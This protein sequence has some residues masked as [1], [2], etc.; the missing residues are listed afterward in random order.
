VG[1]GTI[2]S[3]EVQSVADLTWDIPLQAM[4]GILSQCLWAEQDLSSMAMTL[5]HCVPTVLSILCLTP[6]ICTYRRSCSL[7]LWRVV[8]GSKLMHLDSL[9][10]GL[11]ITQTQ[12]RL[13]TTFI[14][15]NYYTHIYIDWQSFRQL[16]AFT[17]YMNIE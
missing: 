17:M 8:R 2:S 16:Q 5:E 4:T 6:T 14:S 13:L 7:S 1:R 3:E 11:F 15:D 12:F 10:H 9:I